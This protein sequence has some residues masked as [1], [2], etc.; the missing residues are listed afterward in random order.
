MDVHEFGKC[1][2]FSVVLRFYIIT[3]IVDKGVFFLDGAVVAD[4]SCVE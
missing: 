4:G 1:F 2:F 3:H